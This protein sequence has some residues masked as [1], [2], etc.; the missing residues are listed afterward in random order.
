MKFIFVRHALPERAETTMIADPPLTAL[1]R[2]QAE[3]LVRRLASDQIDDIV[4]SPALRAVQT[5]EPIA[6]ARGLKPLVAEELA[7]YDAHEAS[8]VPFEDLRE[9]RDERWERLVRGQFH[10]PHVDP[11]A[12][13]RR[14]VQYVESIV[15][16]SPGRSVLV[17][18]HTGVINAYLGHVLGQET[19]L[20]FPPGYAS[21]SRV[22]AGRD[23]R[24]GIES[25]NEMCRCGR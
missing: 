19:P 12:F 10:T 20:W 1:G 15:E 23:G 22:K 18:T 9:V 17:T 24:R 4:T 6:K 5:A 16:R 11:V 21:M 7:E 14:I 2:R 8:Y 3:D 25:L 13:R